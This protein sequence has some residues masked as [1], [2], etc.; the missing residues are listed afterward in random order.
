[1]N[2]KE[3]RAVVAD[4][5]VLMALMRDNPATTE[6][7]MEYLLAEAR[8]ST[9]YVVHVEGGEAV[10][11][12]RETVESVKLSEIGQMVYNSS[13]DDDHKGEDLARINA[14]PRHTRINEARRLGL[15]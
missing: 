13:A 9:A 3:M 14:L 15:D 7:A 11:D 1:M 6:K 4:R 5:M 12:V 2:D 10:L 8:R